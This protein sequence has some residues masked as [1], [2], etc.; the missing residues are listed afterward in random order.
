MTFLCIEVL[1]GSFFLQQSSQK[2]AFK[3]MVEYNS[4][5]QKD[6]LFDT[7]SLPRE[8]RQNVSQEIP[9]ANF[10]NFYSKFKLNVC[11]KTLSSAAVGALFVSTTDPDPGG[12]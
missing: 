9:V 8:K 6:I 5:T 2:P 1:V 7:D 11:F 4:C 10:F 3:K 12:V